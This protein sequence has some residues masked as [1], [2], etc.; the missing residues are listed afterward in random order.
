MLD[1][2]VLAGYEDQL[3]LIVVTSDISGL[4]DPFRIQTVEGILDKYFRCAFRVVVLA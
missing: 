2:V 1:L 3:S 4:V